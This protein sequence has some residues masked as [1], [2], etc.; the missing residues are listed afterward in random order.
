MKGYVMTDMIDLPSMSFFL[1]RGTSNSQFL[2]NISVS[3]TV[4]ETEEINF[5]FTFKNA[6]SILYFRTISRNQ[7][8]LVRS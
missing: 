5:I 1:Q 6:I 2:K 7:C 3:I 4:S 8:R